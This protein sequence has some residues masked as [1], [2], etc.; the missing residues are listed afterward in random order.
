MDSTQR[1]LLQKENRT[2]INGRVTSLLASKLASSTSHKETVL[3]M[4]KK[5]K[6]VSYRNQ[7]PLLQKRKHSIQE[8]INTALGVKLPTVFHKVVWQ[9][10]HLSWPQFF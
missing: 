8:L 9:F 3:R 2:I 5:M 1:E 6:V 7:E 4:G 10:T